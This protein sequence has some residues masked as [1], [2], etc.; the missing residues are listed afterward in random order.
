VSNGD[1]IKDLRGPFNQVGIGGGSGAAGAAEAFYGTTK[2][3]RPILGAGGTFGGG[4][5]ATSFD[6]ATYTVINYI[7]K[8]PPT[9]GGSPLK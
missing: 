3:G 7:S 1:N 9:P 5:G 4:V 8:A 2:G 6:G